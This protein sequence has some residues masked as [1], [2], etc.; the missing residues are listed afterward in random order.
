MVLIGFFWGGGLLQRRGG[1][2]IG[3]YDTIPYEKIRLMIQDMHILP[4]VMPI[5]ENDF[6]IPT[7]SLEYPYYKIQ[8]P[9]DIMYNLS[10]L[11]LVPPLSSRHE[12]P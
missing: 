6:S 2:I 1:V 7:M 10:E 11:G 12:S 9:G 4:S 8:Y 5:L 3:C